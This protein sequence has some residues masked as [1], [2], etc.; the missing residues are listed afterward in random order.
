MT[1]AH[2]GVCV[3]QCGR[4]VPSLNAFTSAFLAFQLE[5]WYA[6]PEDWHL[7]PRLCRHCFGADFFAKVLFADSQDPHI[8]G[9]QASSVQ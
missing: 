1:L 8:A 4:Q 6:G 7:A 2:L 9:V 5:P 3:G